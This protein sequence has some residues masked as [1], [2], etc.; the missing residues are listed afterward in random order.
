MQ[1]T[2]LD[3]ATITGVT[4][5]SRAVKPGYLFAALPGAVAHGR[6]YIPQAIANGATVILTEDEIA[7]TNSVRFIKVS[8]VR[9]VFSHI[10][11]EF[12]GKQPE[13]IMAVTGTSG[14][15][16]TVIFAEQIMRACGIEGAASLG[17]IGVHSAKGQVKAS[18]TTPGSVSLHETLAALSDEGVTHL[19][20]EASSHGLDQYRM[21]GVRLSAAGFT[22]LSHDH[23]DYH[24]DME[25]Y[26]QAKL[27]LFT[28]VLDGNGTAVLNADNKYSKRI[29][30][31]CKGR[32]IKILTY[33]R[34]AADLQLENVRPVVNGQSVTLSFGGKDYDLTFPLVGEF[35]L[36]NALCALGMVIAVTPKEKQDFAVYIRALEDLVSVPGRLQF[37]DGHPNG[38]AVYVDYAHKPDALKHVLQTIRQ[39]IKGR[40]TCVFGCGGDRDAAKRPLMGTIARELADDVIVTDDNPRSE[41]PFAIR[42]AIMA[43]C[44]EALEIGDRRE[45]IRT[46]VAAS[47]PDDGLVI[48][49]KGHETGQIIGTTTHPF[50]DCEEVLKAFKQ[51]QES[52]KI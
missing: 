27:R 43:T 36:Y 12:Y 35:Q 18:L 24:K 45:A 7:S 14:K 48:A 4:E 29:V 25:S 3:I 6:D 32:S 1:I 20:M 11:A 49:G 15:S 39:H 50:D 41:D 9:Q 23:L 33:G 30:S 8:N 22:N 37:M 46:A 31:I 28:E 42:A 19:A 34:D 13:H 10:V 5:D 17:T 40:L 52:E 26:F 51:T 21:D 44:P 38:A 16:S 2:D 47:G